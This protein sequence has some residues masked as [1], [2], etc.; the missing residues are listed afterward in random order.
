MLHTLSGDLQKAEQHLHDEFAKLQVGRANPAI[1]ESITVMV[2]G[3]VQP[4][5]NVAS[6]GTLDAQTI[7]IQPWD[8]T[9]L[10]DIAKAINDANIGLNPQD[11]GESILIRIPALTE[12]RRRDL[13]KI[14]KKL[15]EEGKVTVRNIRQ[16][17]LKKIKSQD[18]SVSEDIV[19]QQEKDLQKSIDE[20][21]VL[22]D[23][24]TKHKEEEIM[25]I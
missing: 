20:A 9:V 10:R 2:Y 21:I 18:E 1:V 22:V 11:N 17:Y 3:S 4:L 15:S 25:K 6:V 24:M 12:E 14:A 16:D 5:R 7:S 19:K 13:A 8:K 23:K